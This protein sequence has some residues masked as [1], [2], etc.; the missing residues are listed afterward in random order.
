MEEVKVELLLVEL[1]DQ[2]VVVDF[3]L[4]VMLLQ[5]HNNQDNLIV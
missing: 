5:P 2:V 1:V 4:E 3:R